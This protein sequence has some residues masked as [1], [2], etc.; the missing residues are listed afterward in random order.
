MNRTP[1][2]C[3]ASIVKRAR[4]W[5]ETQK[6]VIA[7]NEGEKAKAKEIHRYAAMLLGESV[8]VAERVLPSLKNGGA[9]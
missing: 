2:E 3:N 1:D 9:K 7:A 6:G 8:D 4:Y 5:R